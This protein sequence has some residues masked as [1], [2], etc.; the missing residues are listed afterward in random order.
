M[1]WHHNAIQA[2]LVRRAEEVI[3]AGKAKLEDITTLT[4]PR[5]LEVDG[6]CGQRHVQPSHRN[7]SRR[8]PVSLDAKDVV[9]LEMSSRCA[10]VSGRYANGIVPR[11]SHAF[12]TIDN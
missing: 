10:L 7:E 3:T 8:S 1:K 2:E 4:G 6:K 5:P 11:F 9:D 12:Y